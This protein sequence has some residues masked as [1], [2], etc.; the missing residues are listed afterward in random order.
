MPLPDFEATGDLPAGVHRARL[1]EV[2]QRFSARSGQRGVCTRHLVHAYE[3]AQRT[4]HLQRFIIFGSYVT[5]KPEP[6]DV[7][8]VLVMDDTFHLPECPVEARGLFDH[9]VAQARYGTS[10]F[11]IRPGL[12]FNVSVEDFI[13][14]WQLK[15]DGSTRGIVEVIP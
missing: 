7:D 3:L 5:D 10:V 6:N 4:E 8:V 14:S 11:W 12:L 15:R 2:L 13:G 1:E 9:A